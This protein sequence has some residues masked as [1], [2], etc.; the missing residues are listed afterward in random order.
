MNKREWA[1]KLQ[2]LRLIIRKDNYLDE[3]KDQILNLHSMVY[4]SEM[5]GINQITF[6]NQLWDSLDEETARKAINKK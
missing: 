1:D 2:Q 4:T 6:E 3:A 5:S